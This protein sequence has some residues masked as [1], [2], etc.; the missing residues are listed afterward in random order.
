MKSIN[1]NRTRIIIKNLYCFYQGLKQPV[2]NSEE[3]DN[4]WMDSINGA[5][6]LLKLGY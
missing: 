2:D 4:D 6:Y 5:N 1:H 3:M